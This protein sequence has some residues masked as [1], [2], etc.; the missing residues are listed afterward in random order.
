MNRFILCSI[1]ATNIAFSSSI[2]TSSKN[3]KKSRF[4]KLKKNFSLRY[5]ADY[6]G[7]ALRDLDMHKALGRD[8]IKNNDGT[9]GSEGS[10]SLFNA[11]R[12]NYRMSNGMIPFIQARFIINSQSLNQK[13]ESGDYI[14]ELNTRVGVR[15]FISF[16]TGDVFHGI[17]ANI[18]FAHSTRKGLIYPALNWFTAF[19]PTSK[20]S[21]TLF[22]QFRYYIYNNRE[23]AQSNREYAISFEPSARY[24]LN[25]KVSFV[26]TYDCS[27]K[28]RD[29]NKAWN[30]LI[31]K[32][33]SLLLGPDFTITKDVK[34]NPFI[35]FQARDDFELDSTSLGAWFRVK[36]F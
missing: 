1:I 12:L 10:T 2:T 36:I 17:S 13:N 34:L 26:A 18:D 8:A 24:A 23:E 31:A 15:N 29:G 28:Q 14:N 7:E 30:N 35:D 4:S 6:N 22:S 21:F 5:F 25:E 3:L 33:Q 20:I 16:K 19:S 32:G 27:F 11:L 9:K